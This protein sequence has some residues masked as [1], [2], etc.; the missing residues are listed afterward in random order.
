VE[1]YCRAGQATGD[2]NGACAL[3]AGYLRLHTHTHTHTHAR[4]RAQNTL[5]VLLFHSNSGCKNAPQMLRYTHIACLVCTCI[6]IYR[7][8]SVCTYVC[9]HLR[10]VSVASKSRE[11]TK[12]LVCGKSRWTPAYGSFPA[13]TWIA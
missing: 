11:H 2:N 4:A 1:K 10:T 8:K 13:I 6:H 12:W 7:F 9:V 5:Y 3:H